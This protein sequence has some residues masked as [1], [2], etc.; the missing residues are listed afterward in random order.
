MLHMLAEYLGE[1]LFRDGLRYY[2]KNHAYGNAVT[3]DLW[4][5]LESASADNLVISKQSTANSGG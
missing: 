3:T 1:D 4:A 2:L 5:A